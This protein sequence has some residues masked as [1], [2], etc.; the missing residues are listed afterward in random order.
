MKQILILIFCI[1]TNICFSQ[2]YISP[3]ESINN[4][5]FKEK[6]DSQNSWSY[7]LVDLQVNYVFQ[8]TLPAIVFFR[9]QP[10]K[11]NIFTKS[12]NRKYIPNVYFLIFSIDE[13][14]KIKRVIQD[15]SS[16]TG[17]NVGGGYIVLKDFI[18]YNIMSCISCSKNSTRKKPTDLCFGNILNILE[19]VAE[20]N[21]ETFEELSEALPISRMNFDELI[22][23]VNGWE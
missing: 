2:E 6:I 22:K 19:T 14:D 18:L 13:L 20:K 17:P 1:I 10:L 4:T 23:Q 15:N 11:G 12:Y 21:F 5:D 9:N 8:D 3:R 7:D 16:C